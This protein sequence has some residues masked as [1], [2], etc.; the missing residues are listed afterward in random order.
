[1]DSLSNTLQEAD[2]GLALGGETVENPD[3][4]AIITTL[5]PVSTRVRNGG[6]KFALVKIERYV[7][8]DVDEFKS[9]FRIRRYKPYLR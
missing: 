3:N 7:G 9:K 8:R 1:M 6:V 5:S 2:R 4:T